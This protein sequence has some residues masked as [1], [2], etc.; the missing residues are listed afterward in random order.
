MIIR[1]FSCIA[2]FYLSTTHLFRKPRQQGIGSFIGITGLRRW[3]IGV[4]WLTSLIYHLYPPFLEH[5]HWVRGC[6]E[7]NWNGDRM[8]GWVVAFNC[9]SGWLDWWVPG[10]IG[11]GKWEGSEDEL[12][13]Y[14]GLRIEYCITLVSY[15]I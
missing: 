15:D 4:L 12:S 9:L 1:I 5:V 6:A 13:L 14:I 3:C 2:F 7:R 11:V 8:G 10:F